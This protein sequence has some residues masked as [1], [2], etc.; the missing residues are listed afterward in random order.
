MTSLQQPDNDHEEMTE[1]KFSDKENR[2]ISLISLLIIIILV[3]LVCLMM[4]F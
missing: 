2:N 4:K 1:R 3:L